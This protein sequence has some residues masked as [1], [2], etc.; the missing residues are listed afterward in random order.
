M[1]LNAARHLALALLAEHSLD[2]W[3]FRFDRAKRRLGCCNYTTHTISVS[4]PLT[5]LNDAATVRDTLLHEI[6]HALTPG[7]GHGARWRQA[8]RRIGAKPERCYQND[9]VVQPASRYRLVCP[10]CGDSH[11]RH[12]KTATVYVC[13]PCCQRYN[14]GKPTAAYRLHWQEVSRE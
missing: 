12:R 9:D 14:G 13:S 7:D 2:D 3:S 8:C 11:P 10:T 6:A 4:R 1:K 5:L